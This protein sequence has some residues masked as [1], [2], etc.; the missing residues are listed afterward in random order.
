MIKDLNINLFQFE[1][2]FYSLHRQLIKIKEPLQK[3][4]ELNYQKKVGINLSNFLDH[5]T[6]DQ[7]PVKN[8]DIKTWVT[9]IN[10]DIARKDTHQLYSLIHPINNDRFALNFYN[11]NADLVEKIR[12]KIK[13]TPIKNN[14]DKSNFDQNYCFKLYYP[15][16]VCPENIFKKLPPL[17]TRIKAL[18]EDVAGNDWLTKFPEPQW[19]NYLWEMLEFLKSPA[20]VKSVEKKFIELSK[21][22]FITKAAQLK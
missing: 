18:A 22:K 13:L 4:E 1:G 17:D 6:Y 16:Q 11:V 7:I 2:N 8:Q 15:S 10:Q 12:T 14:I 21:L 5:R 19:H 20:G 9:D 3:K